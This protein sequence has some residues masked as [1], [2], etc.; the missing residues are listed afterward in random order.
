MNEA[1]KFEIYKSP[2]HGKHNFAEG[3][4]KV[5]VEGQ[6][7]SENDLSGDAQREAEAAAI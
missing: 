7:A 2:G 3:V 1:S 5:A 4:A 6:N